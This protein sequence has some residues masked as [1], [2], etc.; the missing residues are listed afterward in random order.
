MTTKNSNNKWSQGYLPPNRETQCPEMPHKEQG[1]H[2]VWKTNS[3][4]I[5]NRWDNRQRYR[6]TERQRNRETE[7]LRDW[8]TERLRDRET[9]RQRDW[10]IERQ[11]LA[12]WQAPTSLLVSVWVSVRLSIRSSRRAERWDRDKYFSLRLSYWRVMMAVFSEREW[13]WCLS[14]WNKYSYQQIYKNRELLENW[15]S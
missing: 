11:I 1:C 6:E 2:V 15:W 4:L 3:Y 9:E 7:R 10:K 13:L 14:L 8:E 5:V 12:D